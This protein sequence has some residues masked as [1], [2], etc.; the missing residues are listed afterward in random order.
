MTHSA[1]DARRL[2]C[3]LGDHLR[4]T[5]RGARGIDMAAV[6]SHTAADTIYGIDRVAD[7]VHHAPQGCVANRNHDRAVKVDDLHSA[8]HT[9]S[10]QHRNRTNA[11]FTEVLLNFGDY[12]DLGFDIETFGRNTHCLINRREIIV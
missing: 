1:E 8:D 4:E 11:A 2:L 12:V 9:V 5:L 6:D 3:L 7:D 10:R